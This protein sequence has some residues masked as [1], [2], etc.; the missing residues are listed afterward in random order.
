M[1]KTLQDHDRTTAELVLSAYTNSLLP[2]PG[3]NGEEDHGIDLTLYKEVKEEI[4]HLLKVSPS[5]LS[6]HERGRVFEFLA[7][8]MSEVALAGADVKRIKDQLG[9]RGQLR[10]DLYEIEFEDSSFR[11]A[12]IFGIRKKHVMEAIRHP[13]LVEEVNTLSSGLVLYLKTHNKMNERDRFSLVV[14]SVRT[15]STIYVRTAFRIYHSDVGVSISLSPTSLLKAL[16]ETY[17][18]VI[19][20]GLTEAKFLSEISIEE[21]AGTRLSELIKTRDPGKGLAHVVIDE[22]SIGRLYV[23]R[24]V[25]VI[26]RI[27]YAADLRRRGVH[28]GNIEELPPFPENSLSESSL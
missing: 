23:L 14:T 5:S 19:R 4:H 27:S 21:S 28:V 20:V 22:S 18:M 9:E 7:R 26:D 1:L 11:V 13:D 12:E 15:G 2:S 16:A 6:Q 17:G 24:L 25:F 10:P 8:E 3:F